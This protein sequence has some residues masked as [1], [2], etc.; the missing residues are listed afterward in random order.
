MAAW[1]IEETE[2]G[3]RLAPVRRRAMGTEAFTW[4]DL[5]HFELSAAQVYVLYFPSR[6]ALPVDAAATEALRAFGAATGAGTTVAF[7]DPTDPVFSTALAFFALEVPP[8]LVLVRGRATV[9]RRSATLEPSDLYA[10]TITDQAVLADREWLATAVNSIHEV[11]VRADPRE[12][13][14]YLRERSARSVL[15]AIGRVAAR[16]RDELLALKPSFQLPG[17]GSISV[18]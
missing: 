4:A 2:R 3:L 15:A 12:I 17:G 7:W 6:F 11:L 1:R 9:G 13:A 16:L 5:L 14:G 10:I 18:G 8:A